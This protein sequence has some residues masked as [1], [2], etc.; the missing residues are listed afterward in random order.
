M[1]PVLLP[2]GVNND[3]QTLGSEQVLN[4]LGHG[5]EHARNGCC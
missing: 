1:T 2:V 4:A 3:A 5:R